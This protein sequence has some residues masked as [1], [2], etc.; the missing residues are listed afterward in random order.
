MSQ[1]AFLQGRGDSVTH[2]VVRSIKISDVP[3]AKGDVQDFLMQAFRA[4]DD[5]MAEYAMHA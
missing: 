2:V 3:V 1:N 5:V 4:K